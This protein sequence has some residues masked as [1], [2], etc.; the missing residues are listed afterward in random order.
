MDLINRAFR[1]AEGFILERD[2]VDLE[3][4]QSLLTRGG[5]LLAE[6]ENTL[7]GCVYLEHKGERISGHAVG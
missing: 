2:R 4:I 5:F 1:Q 3:L 7:V 6:D